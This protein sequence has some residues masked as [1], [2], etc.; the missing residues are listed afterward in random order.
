NSDTLGP[1]TNTAGITSASTPDPDT[2]NNSD[3]ELTDVVTSADLSILKSD[4]PDPVTAGTTLTYTLLV[5]NAGP[6]DALNVTVADSLPADVSFVSAIS[7][8]GTC[9]SSVACSLG[10]LVSGQS[11]TITIVV[12]VDAG[13]LGPLSNTATVTSDTS[14]PA[15]INNSDTELTDVETVADLSIVKGDDPDPVTAGT[16]LT[17][18]LLVQNA[19]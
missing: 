2:G 16:T 1:L 18:T 5:H 11:V 12:H 3:T 6:S 9:D 13:T 15:P 4:T 8:Q 10:T 14:D 17:Y 19:G 7:T